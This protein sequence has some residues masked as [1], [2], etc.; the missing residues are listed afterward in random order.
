MKVFLIAMMAA[1]LAIMGDFLKLCDDIIL[2]D[3]RYLFMEC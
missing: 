3:S 2:E 1:G